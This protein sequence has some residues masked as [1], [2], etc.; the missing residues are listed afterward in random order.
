VGW[1]NH[2]Y[3]VGAL[4]SS[5]NWMHLAIVYVQFVW[6]MTEVIMRV[7]GRVVKRG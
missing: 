2:I 7:M 3:V 1:I 4:V 6:F 5:S